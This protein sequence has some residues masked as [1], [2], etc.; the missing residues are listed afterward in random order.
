MATLKTTF[1]ALIALFSLTAAAETKIA[2][3]DLAKAI[4]SSELAQKRLDELAAESNL[5]KLKAEFDG[6]LA[7]AQGL[8]KEFE[9]NSL[10]WDDAK[11]A[12][13][14]RELESY[15]ADLALLQRKLQAEQQAVQQSLLQEIQPVAFEQLQAVIDEEKIDILINKEAALWNNGSVDITNKL[16]DRI[17]KSVKK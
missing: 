6:K 7:D 15:K 5:A 14:N 13:T 4:T 10:S 17:N 9:T 12:K 8:Q 11:K 3:C 2:V 16:I 1:F